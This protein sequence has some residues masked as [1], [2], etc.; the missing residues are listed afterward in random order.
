MR[1]WYLHELTAGL[2]LDLFV[3]F[4]SV[5]AVLGR[6]RGRGELRGGEYVSWTGWRRSGGR[7]VCRHGCRW[8][9]RCGCTGRGSGRDLSEVDVARVAPVPG[10]T[11]PVSAAAG[12]QP[13]SMPQSARPEAFLI[14]ARRW[15]LAGMRAAERWRASPAG[16]LVRA[17]RY[18]GPRGPAP[19]AGVPVAGG[20]RGG[21]VAVAWCCSGSAAGGS[22]RV[23][24]R[25][26]CWGYASASWRWIRGVRSVRSGLIL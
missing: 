19:V 13:C 9:G 11:G 3:L 20:L 26:R 24:M 10:I 2:D 25:R 15:I 22:W 16:M 23:R 8:R 14:P 4:S 17:A 1:G 6:F 12:L 18:L 21:V 7:R 5:A